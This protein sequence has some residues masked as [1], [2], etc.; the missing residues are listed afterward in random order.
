MFY[1]LNNSYKFK[2]RLQWFQNPRNFYNNYHNFYHIFIPNIQLRL[3][4]S[5]IN[6]P[7]DKLSQFLEAIKKLLTIAIPLRVL[8]NFLNLFSFFYTPTI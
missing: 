5:A 4:L 7:N 1:I 3:I 2:S 8:F 6:C